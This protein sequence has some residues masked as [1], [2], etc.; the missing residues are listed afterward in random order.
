MFPL[1]QVGEK[2]SFAGL[3]LTNG[4]VISECL[5]ETKPG[6]FGVLIGFQIHEFA[7]IVWQN[8]LLLDHICTLGSQ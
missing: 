5:V 7:Y 6:D 3:V 4:T 2:G 8:V 1:L